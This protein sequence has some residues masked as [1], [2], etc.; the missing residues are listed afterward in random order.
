MGRYSSSRVGLTF[1]WLFFF[2]PPG[3][4]SRE[5]NFLGSGRTQ[6]AA[7]ADIPV[8]SQ[9]DSGADQSMVPE[10]SRHG[11]HAL[12]VFGPDVARGIHVGS[13]GR[14]FYVVTHVSVR[15]KLENGVFGLEPFHL[16][17][18]L[19][20]LLQPACFSFL[21]GGGSDSYWLPSPARPPFALLYKR[22]L[23]KA[24]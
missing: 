23:R 17:F 21:Q 20:L 6:W 24:P 9:V 22:D 11:N 8:C 5:G 1:F 16:P 3:S 2:L 14:R 4:N 15:S 19:S 12:S 18:E 7:L 10:Y 13:G